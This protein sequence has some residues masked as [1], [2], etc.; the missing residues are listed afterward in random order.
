MWYEYEEGAT[1]VVSVVCSRAV[2]RICLRIVRP[3]AQSGCSGLK[4]D[5]TVR[6]A[7]TMSR[8]TEA[9][10]YSIKARGGGWL[11]WRMGTEA[12][13]NPSQ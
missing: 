3:R 8:R 13:Q 2:E 5:A 6:K 9:S 12:R 7:R 1:F 4:H 10:V 11:G